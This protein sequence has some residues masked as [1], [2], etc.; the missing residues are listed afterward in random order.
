[1]QMT[2]YSAANKPRGRCTS[3]PLHN[4]DEDLRNSL[5]LAVHAATVRIYQFQCQPLPLR[6]CLPISGFC[7]LAD[8]FAGFGGC[9]AIS[10]Y[11]LLCEDDAFFFKAEADKASLR[12][13]LSR[14]FSCANSL[15]TQYN[16]GCSRVR[17]L[18]CR[19]IERVGFNRECFPATASAATARPGGQVRQPKSHRRRGSRVNIANRVSTPP[20]TNF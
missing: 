4:E 16:F 7:R 10:V 6:C 15:G 18:K 9:V 13:E 5:S 14:A 1:M 19:N 8:V 3:A 2:S 20:Q 12:Q 11:V 17:S